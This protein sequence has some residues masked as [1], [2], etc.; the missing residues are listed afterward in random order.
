MQ[1]RGKSEKP[2][3]LTKTVRDKVV[4]NVLA[5]T[6]VGLVYRVVN[7]EISDVWVGGGGGGGGGGGYH[8]LPYQCR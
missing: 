8:G 2:R 3:E 7:L 1:P 5:M 6:D 4:L